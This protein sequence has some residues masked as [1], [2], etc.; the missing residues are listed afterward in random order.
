[1]TTPRP[2]PASMRPEAFD[3]EYK[4]MRLEWH[5]RR[6]LWLDEGS[7]ESGQAWRSFAHIEAKLRKYLWDKCV[8]KME[9]DRRKHPKA[10]RNQ[11]AVPERVEGETH[12]SRWTV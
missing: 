10:R 4:S 2:T 1:M 6:K 12:P 11:I 9:E 5:H 8:A 7:P 3:P